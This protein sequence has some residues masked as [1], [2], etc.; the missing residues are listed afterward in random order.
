MVV[1][2][3]SAVIVVVVVVTGSSQAW[4]IKKMKKIRISSR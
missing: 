2:V 3:D 4:H 1:V